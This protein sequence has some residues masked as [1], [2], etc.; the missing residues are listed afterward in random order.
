MSLTNRVSLIGFLGKDAET[1]STRNN[2]R[3]TVLSLA[4][5]RS[6][7]DRQT[8]EWQSK[9]TWHRIICWGRLADY[10][11]GFSKGAHLQMEGEI[12]TRDYTP[13]SGGKKT[14]TEVRAIQ[15]AKLTRP[16]KDGES[17]PVQGSRCLTA[18]LSTGRHRR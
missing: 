3:F 5:K 16:K 10:A 17:A 4:T 1:K 14:I 6:W 18:A 15:I 11:A 12:T 8:G 7:K 2:A 13:Q 9:S